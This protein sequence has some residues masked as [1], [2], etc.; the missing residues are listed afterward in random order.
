MPT[1]LYWSTVL[2]GSDYTTVAYGGSGYNI[3]NL[4]LE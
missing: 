3:F 2:I 4:H 1:V